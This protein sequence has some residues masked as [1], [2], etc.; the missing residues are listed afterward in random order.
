MFRKDGG[1]AEEN[2]H[3]FQSCSTAHLLPDYC[4]ILQDLA[5]L[6]LVIFIIFPQVVLH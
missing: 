2:L 1:F 5:G 3:P 4:F 6:K